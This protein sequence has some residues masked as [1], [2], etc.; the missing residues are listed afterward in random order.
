VG[1]LFEVTPAPSAAHA[2]ATG[3]APAGATAASRGSKAPFAPLAWISLG[4]T[5]VGGA[6]TIIAWQIR[7]PAADDFN[8][9]NCVVEDDPTRPTRAQTCSDSL[10]TVKSAE[11]AMVIGGIATGVFAAL[12]TVFFVLDAT[13]GG[14][15][16]HASAGPCMPGP[17][18]IGLACRVAF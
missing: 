3:S 11:T 12:T 17:G 18:D 14:S 8:A 9:E 16:E 4:G 1:T 15:V 2:S 13:V 7:E 6:A 10:G 5:V